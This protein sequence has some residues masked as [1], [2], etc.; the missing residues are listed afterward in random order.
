MK[1]INKWKASILC[2][3]LILTIFLCAC[4]GKN[5]TSITDYEKE[6][7]SNN[8]YTGKLFAEDLCVSES[9]VELTGYEEDK[10][11]QAAALY[12]QTD[13]NVLYSYSAHKKV[14]PASITKIMTAL[15][16]L[17]NGNLQ[18]E[19]VI[20]ANADASSFPVAAQVCG[21]KKGQTWTLE[22]LL[23][24]LLL[25]SGNDVAVAIAEHIGGTE[26][27]FVQ[28]MNE[29][30]K[31]LM[32]CNTHYCNPHGLHEDDHYTTAYDIY[33]IF[34][35]CIQDERFVNIINQDSCTVSYKKADGSY[36]EATFCATN[37]YAKG[38]AEKP[39]NVMILGGKTGTTDEGGYCLIL[40]EKDAVGKDYIS[41]VMGA[42]EKGLLYEDMTRLIEAIP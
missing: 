26:E 11:V 16:A 34:Q 17:E 31:E 13:G 37:Y 22:A 25:Y 40:L 24:A 14:Y 39:D 29:R 10:S 28:M 41:I 9:D 33:L 7:Y 23:N 42:S 38:L 8:L 6:N 21:I 12:A 36:A 4:D 20:S 2:G 27:A 35:K 32:A 30:A 19:V 18:D 3:I 1:C 5:Q 15:L